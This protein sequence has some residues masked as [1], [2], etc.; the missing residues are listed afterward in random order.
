M[1][2]IYL[3][4]LWHQHQ[5]IYKNPLNDV[6]ELPWVRLHAV[7]DYYDMVSILDEFPKIKININLVPS[8]L[9]QLD[10]YAR[11]IAKDIFVE[12]TL[13]NAANLT[14]DDK[15]FI[16]KNFFMANFDHMIAANPRYMQLFQK[17]GASSESGG[18]Q[19]AIDDFK[20]EDFR[21]LQ[22]WF[23]LSWMDPFWRSNDPLIK[24][25]YEKGRN[26]TEED[27]ILLIQKHFWICGE[28][29][30]KH[31]QAQDNKQIEVSVTPFYHP[32]LPLLCDTNSARQSMPSVVLPEKF[33]H[34]EDAAFQ[35]NSAV[36]YYEK[37]FGRKPKGMWPSE[38]SVS[39]ETAALISESGIKWIATDEA[40]LYGSKYNIFNGI[41][42]SCSP[43][44]IVKDGRD[45][46]L[47]IIFRNTN[48]SDSIGFVYS[49][50]N[51]EDAVNDF[52]NKLNAIRN[53]AG[54][55]EP[56]IN[57]ILDGENCWEYY[58]NDGWDFLR[59]LYQRI[60]GD[61]S[62]ETVLIGDY[63]ERF[64]PSNTIEYLRAGSWIYGNFSIW[65]GQSEDNEAWNKLHKTRKFLVD[66]LEK[67]PSLKGSPQEK[68]A[69]DNLYIAEGSDW[70]WW[71]G[72]DHS[73]GNDDM[74]DFLFRQRLIKV[75]NCLGQNA[76]ESLYT[77]IK[78][79]ASKR[80]HSIK[81]PQ[82]FIS[83]KIDGKK[84]SYFKWKDAAFC[85]MG[86]FGGSM[87]Q[88]DVIVNSFFYG[89]D[90]D[91]FYLRLDLNNS[92]SLDIL[93][94]LT[95]NIIFSAP[96][97]NR[98]SV[99]F[100]ETGNLSEFVLSRNGSLQNLPFTD[101]KYRE[102][103][104]MRIPFSLLDFPP[105]YENAEFFIIVDR[106]NMEIERCPNR[107]NAFF[108]KPDASLF[109]ENWIV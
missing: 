65:I 27:K 81:P 48:L 12:M 80:E 53:G 32:I 78:R 29:V 107:D 69:W 30:K 96:S 17:R 106:D 50:W 41:Q 86:R 90:Y 57:V 75:Y 36:K 62:I 97:K 40:V 82:S 8:L 68:E 77:P 85:Q 5:P 88:V 108:K 98:I 67:N 15:N 25:L 19:K 47:N 18:L 9:I 20:T 59:S 49:K 26:F 33:S 52:M 11:G 84:S 83:P 45:L 70:N 93:K 3:S 61:A 64:P 24:N 73:S 71:Y 38:G 7:K 2:K 16:L 37:V 21:D 92:I 4:F 109:C 43:F 60:S 101:A 89:F 51:T 14:A 6:Y 94:T 22:T 46:N 102:I 91:Y 105:Q 87:H 55:P 63:L 74:F 104:E 28:I 10:E 44:K 66:F 1:K 103:I 42:P 34:P 100:D 56:L 13:K 31:R 72:N 35:I 99:S 23:N 95:F 54:A 76:D 39:N 79:S 58:K